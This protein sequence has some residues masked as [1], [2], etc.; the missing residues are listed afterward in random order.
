MDA[1]EAHQGREDPQGRGEF[2]F[3][4]LLIAIAQWLALQMDGKHLL[5]DD[6]CCT[7]VGSS[8]G[9]EKGIVCTILGL[10]L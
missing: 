5:F 1:I 3:F 9:L 7:Q 6:L 10:V 4:Y 2:F 8:K